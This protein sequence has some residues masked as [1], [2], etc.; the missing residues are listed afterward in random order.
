MK[1]KKIYIVNIALIVALMIGLAGCGGGNL[2]VD[3]C[4]GYNPEKDQVQG[5]MDYIPKGKQVYMLLRNDQ[6]FGEEVLTLS[7]Y[8][9]N[10]DTEIPIA[11]TSVKIEK[12][13]L[14]SLVPVNFGTP[15][16]YYFRFST[17]AGVLIDVEKDVK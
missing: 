17:A 12:L 1:D 15:G 11:G 13:F 9:K 10:G 3:I 16:K 5:K 8:Q 14:Y 4:T 2:K 7:I 6:P